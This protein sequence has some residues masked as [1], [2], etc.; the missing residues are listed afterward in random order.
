MGTH[1][2]LNVQIDGTVPEVLS[3][4]PSPGSLSPEQQRQTEPLSPL[5]AALRI[6]Q[7]RSAAA[8]DSNEPVVTVR[9]GAPSFS[10]SLPRNFSST[11]LS[12]LGRNVQPV[13]NLPSTVPRVRPSMPPPAPPPSGVITGHEVT[14]TPGGSQ[15]PIQPPSGTLLSNRLQE[16]VLGSPADSGRSGAGSTNPAPANASASTDDPEA[17]EENSASASD[18]VPAPLQQAL[19]KMAMRSR[20]EDDDSSRKYSLESTDSGADADTEEFTRPTTA[21][22]TTFS[23]ERV[24][25]DLDQLDGVARGAAEFNRYD[26][27]FQ[28]LPNHWLPDDTVK[29]NVS[30]PHPQP[31]L[32]PQHEQENARP[33]PQ[34]AGIPATPPTTPPNV[35][36]SL[37]A[38]SQEERNTNNGPAAW[39]SR[40]TPDPP[41]AVLSRLE[42]PAHAAIVHAPRP[43]ELSQRIRPEDIRPEPSRPHYPFAT[44][45]HTEDSSLLTR[46]EREQEQHELDTRNAPETW[47]YRST[48]DAPRSEPSSNQLEWAYPRWR[49]PSIVP[50]PQTDLP[51]LDEYNR[52]EIDIEDARRQAL[53]AGSRAYYDNPDER[54]SP[55]SLVPRHFT[56]ADPNDPQSDHPN[57]WTFIEGGS[58]NQSWTDFMPGPLHRSRHVS[59]AEHTTPELRQE[60]NE[61]VPG[62]PGPVAIPP[63]VM[64]ADDEPSGLMYQPDLEVYPAPPPSRAQSVAQPSVPVHPA[65]PGNN[66]GRAP[67]DAESETRSSVSLHPQL[68]PGDS[69]VRARDPALDLPGTPYLSTSDESD[70]VVMAPTPRRRQAEQARGRPRERDSLVHAVA[71]E[72]SRERTQPLPERTRAPSADE[73]SPPAEPSPPAET[74]PP[75]DGTSDGEPPWLARVMQPRP[76]HQLRY[77]RNVLFYLLRYADVGDQ[78]ARTA[79]EAWGSETLQLIN[80]GSHSNSAARPAAVTDPDRWLMLFEELTT[81]LYAI[82]VARADMDMP[83]LNRS[84]LDPSTAFLGVRELG[85]FYRARPRTGGVRG[86]VRRWSE[87]AGQRM[88]PPVRDALVDRFMSSLPSSPAASDHESAESAERNRHATGLGNP[89]SYVFS[90]D[91]HDDAY[92]GTFRYVSLRQQ[93]QYLGA[94]WWYQQRL[95]RQQSLRCHRG[96]HA[97]PDIP[98]R[99]L[100]QTEVSERLRRAFLDS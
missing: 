83:L 94:E 50:R 60:L 20:G 65:E 3:S 74:S 66:I 77:V 10:S 14:T 85:S 9:G 73:T 47:H 15:I 49:A 93:N 7:E 59:F 53:Q 22:T 99:R 42:L 2:P 48:P 28:G 82:E 18:H 17:T 32:P 38:R 98:A 29:T 96:R 54:L 64:E 33:N 52:D 43:E 56:E 5:E 44:A 8:D 95:R 91:R 71:R 75:V 16:L 51:I 26:P 40:T 25:Q 45:P 12:A 31:G 55:T 79:L 1:H 78:D 70:G 21:S 68:G 63:T 90:I 34:P 92:R 30:A 27:D 36:S 58:R 62:E 100:P 39:H 84:I 67:L 87:A 57:N 35:G 76:Y 61:L 4:E 81:T 97:H 69:I 13:V 72:R 19:M 6:A 24:G 80:G 86:R 37:L 41:G 89:P 23:Y 88:P 46:I 11:A